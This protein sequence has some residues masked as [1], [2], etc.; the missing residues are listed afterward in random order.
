MMESEAPAL[1]LIA[2]FEHLAEAAR[3]A[4]DAYRREATDRTEA[5]ARERANAFRRLNLVRT[6]TRAIAEAEDPEKALARVRFIVAGALGFDEIGPR[7]TLVLD[8]LMPVF[9]AM[10][11]EMS[12]SEGTAGLATGAALRGFEDWYRQETG[13]EFYAL[14]ERYMPDTPRVD[15]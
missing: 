1:D 11:A 9:E 8:Q 3:R 10:Q 2:S 12:A 4:E 14:F 7:Q 15:F 13:T 6:A 5:L